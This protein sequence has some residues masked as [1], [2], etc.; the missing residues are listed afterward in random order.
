MSEQNLL[1]ERYKDDSLCVT[2]L[3]TKL[4]NRLSTKVCTQHTGSWAQKSSRDRKTAK[5]VQNFSKPTYILKER[6]FLKSLLFF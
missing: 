4:L 5:T 1:T 3:A 2:V 6:Y